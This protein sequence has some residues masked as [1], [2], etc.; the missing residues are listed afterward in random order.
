MSAVEGRWTIMLCKDCGQRA[1]YQDRCP[2][3][4]RRVWTEMVEMP[5]VPCDDAAV[6]RGVD[7]FAGIMTVSD[8]R[9]RRAIVVA[10]LQA[11]GR[12]ES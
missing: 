11:A 5:V 7:S 3:D 12:V 4:R 2:K 6:E 9:V 10:V 1:H 8:E